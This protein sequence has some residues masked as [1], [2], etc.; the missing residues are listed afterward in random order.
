M[1]RVEPPA[2][3]PYPA[4]WM[5]YAVHGIALIEIAVVLSPALDIIGGPGDGGGREMGLFFFIL[6]PFVPIL[7]G[8]AAFHFGSRRFIR[9]AGVALL[10][11]P[12]AAIIWIS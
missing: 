6:L 7:A 2:G 8:L 5:M 9:G 3:A 10:L 1:P 12:L 4:S 11:P